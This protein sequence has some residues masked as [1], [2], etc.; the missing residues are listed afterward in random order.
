MSPSSTQAAPA[1][2]APPFQL[3]QGGKPKRH[4]ALGTTLVTILVFATL[5][6]LWMAAYGSQG[7]VSDEVYSVLRHGRNWLSGQ[8]FVF[9]QGVDTGLNQPL[10]LY[11]LMVAPLQ[12]ALGDW[13]P[14]FLIG[15][16]T[17]LWTCAVLALLR[18]MRPSVR[19]ALALLLCLAPAFVDGAIR[20]TSV[21]WLGFLLAMSFAAISAGRTATSLVWLSMAV[22]SNPSMWLFLPVWIGVHTGRLGVRFGSGTLV[23][24]RNAL[25]V[26]VPIGLWTFLSGRSTE[27]VLWMPLSDW[28]LD[29]RFPWNSLGDLWLGL[30][31]FSL[32]PWVAEA[33][34]WIQHASALL[35]WSLVAGV[36][37]VNWRTP[38][39][40]S[41]GWLAFFYLQ[42]FVGT[43]AGLDRSGQT[44]T[45][46]LPALALAMAMVPCLLPLVPRFHQTRLLRA[47]AIVLVTL[48]MPI[49]FGTSLDLRAKRTDLSA[50]ADYLI[51]A[52]GE[53]P[54]IVGES[55]LVLEA[56]HL[57][58][59]YA[60]P[61]FDPLDR[62]A[63]DGAAST[64]FAQM[65][66]HS[67]CDW[68]LVRESE[69]AQNRMPRVG[70]IW[71]S[72]ADHDWW[73]TH[74]HREATF[75]EWHLYRV[76]LPGPK[77]N[78]LA[79]TPAKREPTTN[80]PG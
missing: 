70:K 37:W 66:Q 8:A 67:D 65:A 25:A 18:P 56:A 77:P 69:L 1:Q 39:I 30:A 9:Q 46:I 63:G 23:H 3:L 17:V 47:S 13:T 76:T 20:G 28:L 15:F 2:V 7:L 73:N 36:T 53:E 74:A 38:T 40:G 42:L 80:A 31:S 79:P 62:I 57:G 16:N 29:L 12:R 32:L 34:P 10:S 22:L 26:L 60:G 5:F 48:A 14:G 21:E 33:S 61:V 50:A 44:V 58:Y 49:A 59:L 71:G 64:P 45:S 11:G 4:M 75:G 54:E 55:V 72:D 35:T 6:R 27:H 52:Q 51:A 24:W 41:R 78:P 43:G 19:P 68:F